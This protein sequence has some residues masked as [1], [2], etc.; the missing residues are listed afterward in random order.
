MVKEKMEVLP[1][2]PHRQGT[3]CYHGN[4]IQFR[5]MI[6]LQ[7][8]QIIRC[9]TTGN[10]VR[11]CMQEMDKKIIG[12]KKQ[13]KYEENKVLLESMTEWLENVKRPIL[14]QQSYIRLES[15]IRVQIGKSDIGHVR[16]KFV[17]TDDIQK[18]INDKNRQGLSHSTIKKIYDCLNDY[19]RYISAK[20]D[21]KNPMTLVVMPTIGNVCSEMKKIEFFEDK[22]IK[23]FIEECGMRWKTGNLKYPDGYVL[24]ANIYL[25]M[26]IGEL[27]ALTWKDIDFEKRTIYINKTII[28]IKNPEYDDTMPEKM[29]QLGIHKV[30]FVVQNSTKRNK[31][32]YIPINS[33]AKELL[34]LHK[35]NSKFIEPDDF[36][37]SSR[38]RKSKSPKNIST[39]IG[40]I[41]ENAGTY[42]RSTGTHILRHTCASLY[43]RKGVPIETICTILGNSREVCEKTYVHLLEEQ[44]KEAASKIDIIEI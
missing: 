1:K 16:Y 22:D 41:E 5:K 19:Y 23:K 24:A 13:K 32:R 31:N 20:K 7:D 34:L 4:K 38:N 17:T 3:F 11:E 12:A 15:I 2:L 43:F 42:V 39:T 14:K 9:V 25:G 18:L 26:R 44:L 27:L 10:T 6:H 21:I 8:G 28:E 33:R 35:E 36:V 29:K 40:R 37:I 30:I